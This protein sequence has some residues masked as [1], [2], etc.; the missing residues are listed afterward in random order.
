[1]TDKD[2][3][4]LTLPPSARRNY[5]SSLRHTRR[6]APPTYRRPCD[7]AGAAQ[8]GYGSSAVLAAVS[9]RGLPTNA[10]GVAG[11]SPSPTPYSHLAISSYF[12]GDGRRMRSVP[13]SLRHTNFPSTRSNEERLMFGSLHITLPVFHSTHRSSASG[14]WYPLDP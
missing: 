1:M 10:P 2:G 8:A 5:L 6:P 11:S 4:E 14:A 9:E 3:F 13:S 12:S 7:K